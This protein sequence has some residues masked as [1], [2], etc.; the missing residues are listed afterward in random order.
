VYQAYTSHQPDLALD[1]LIPPR[2]SAVV[3][4]ENPNAEGERGR[5][6]RLVAEKGRMAW[7]RATSYDR[8]SL[9][10]A[11]VERHKTIIGP[12]LRARNW[13]AQQGDAAIATEVLNR[14]IRVAKPVPVRAA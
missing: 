8:R 10:A 11:V 1:V 2:I 6:V 5:R 13:P 14:M 3:D 12:K 4:T 7:Q 9:A